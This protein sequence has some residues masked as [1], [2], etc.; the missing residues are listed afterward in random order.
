MPNT[1]LC[2]FLMSEDLLI[3]M[4]RTENNLNAPAGKATTDRREVA[5]SASIG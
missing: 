3:S 5:L 4:P 2:F 1:V